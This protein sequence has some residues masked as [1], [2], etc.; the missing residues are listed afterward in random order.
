MDE[1]YY[2]F[3]TYFVKSNQLLSIQQVKFPQNDFQQQ[4]IKS[5]VKE[6][7]KMKKIFNFDTS[8]PPKKHEI[9]INL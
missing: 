1:N 4:K 8:T 5:S 2:F 6:Q 9:I 3:F 7:E